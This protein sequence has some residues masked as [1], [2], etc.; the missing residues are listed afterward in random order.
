MATDELGPVVVEWL[1]AT[2]H[3]V[4]N[5][6]FTEMVFQSMLELPGYLRTNGFKTFIVSGDGVEF[7]R[8]FAEITYGTPFPSL[9]R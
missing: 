2:R 7:M 3:P 4:T 6:L 1:A 8:A 5:K 9:R